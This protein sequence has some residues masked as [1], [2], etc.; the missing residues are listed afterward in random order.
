MN[1]RVNDYG[2]LIKLQNW[3]EIT[4]DFTCQEDEVRSKLKALDIQGYQFVQSMAYI[5]TLVNGMILTWPLKHILDSRSCNSHLSMCVTSYRLFREPS[6]SS[7]I[8][9]NSLLMNRNYKPS[10]FSFFYTDEL[11][12]ASMTFEMWY[13][14]GTS[15]GRVF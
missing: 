10:M 2:G 12:T 9:F 15:E 5:Y 1:A 13:I 3:V 4:S 7:L 14:F 6:T 8:S 11:I